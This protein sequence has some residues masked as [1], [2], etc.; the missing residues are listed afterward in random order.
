M[1]KMSFI[2]WFLIFYFILFLNYEIVAIENIV[3]I[4]SFGKE[5]NGVYWL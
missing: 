2:S 5:N 1:V 4:Q 3:K